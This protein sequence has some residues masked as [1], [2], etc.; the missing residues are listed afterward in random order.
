MSFGFAYPVLGIKIDTD[1][2]SDASKML[3]LFIELILSK[4]NSTSVEFE[5]KKTC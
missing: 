2:K 4:K 1:N 5:N 3:K